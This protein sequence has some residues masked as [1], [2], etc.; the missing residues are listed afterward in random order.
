MDDIALT[1]GVDEESRIIVAESGERDER[2][3]GEFVDDKLQ[4]GNDMSLR[5]TSSAPS[6]APRVG[7]VV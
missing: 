2:G 4:S 7:W 5:Q 1:V 6:L 3:D